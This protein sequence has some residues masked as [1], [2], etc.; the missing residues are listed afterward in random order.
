MRKV[1][2][3]VRQEPPKESYLKIYEGIQKFLLMDVS[4]ALRSPHQTGE[5]KAVIYF[6]G[7]ISHGDGD[8]VVREAIQCLTDC[9]T[10]NLKS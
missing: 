2:P 4:F 6:R 5:P 10:S 8:L 1:Q 9:E 3:K 7:R